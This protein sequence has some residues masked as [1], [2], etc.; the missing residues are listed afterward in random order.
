MPRRTD[1]REQMIQAAVELF[2]EN[3][4][5]AT[6]LVGVVEASATPRGSVYYHF[7][8]GK[9]ELALESTARVKATV[10]DLVDN[11]AERTPGGAGELVSAFFAFHLEILEG[12][13]FRRGCPVAT[14][15][16][17]M[18]DT[19]E[20]R[21]AINAVFGAWLDAFAAQFTAAGME[22]DRARAWASLV[23]STFE[24]ALI[25]ARVSRS[26]EPLEIARRELSTLIRRDCAT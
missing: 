15:A 10:V 16:L 13:G 19:A 7:P 8:G 6:S 5:F 2:A 3:G 9:E 21:D 26:R 14:V 24:G 17:E 1:A 22:T 20:L 4:F 18:S 23:I 25:Q 12:S 11:L